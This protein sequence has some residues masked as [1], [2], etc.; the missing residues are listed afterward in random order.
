MGSVGVDRC[1]SQIP[2]Q[3]QLIWLGS[4]LALQFWVD[5]GSDGQKRLILSR[6][7]HD[8]ETWRCTLSF[9]ETINGSP[10]GS[11]TRSDLGPWSKFS[12]RDRNFA[13]EKKTLRNFRSWFGMQWVVSRVKVSSQRSMFLIYHLSSCYHFFL[14]VWSDKKGLFTR[15]WT[16]NQTTPSTDLSLSL[17]TWGRNLLTTSGYS[18]PTSTDSRW[19]SFSY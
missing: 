15:P 18:N 13:R 2:V 11:I 19:H 8:N 5:D 9:M 6:S 14:P 17:G 7:S 4:V 1:L 12:S 16:E 10:H 3:F